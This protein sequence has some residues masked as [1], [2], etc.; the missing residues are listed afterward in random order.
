M[1][2]IDVNEMNREVIA[3]LRANGGKVV[4]G[5][6]AGSDLLL[7]HTR[8]A[9]SGAARIN[10]LMYLRDGERYV[11]FASRNGGPR[12]PDWYFNL[13]RNPEVEVEV[14]QERFA[15]TALITDGEERERVWAHCVAQR[16]FLA[17]MASKALP[18]VLPVIALER[19]EA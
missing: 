12:H 13:L 18:R 7:L 8:G 15:A 14:G 19:R 6:F 10:P 5:R 4:S 17:D 11:I 16:P 9:K 1:S 2:E 3:Q